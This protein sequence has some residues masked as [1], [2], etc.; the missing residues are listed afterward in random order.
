MLHASVAGSMAHRA[1]MIKI[2]LDEFSLRIKNAQQL[3]VKENIDLLFAFG[4]EAEPQYQ[5]YFSNYWPSFETAAVIIGKIGEPILLVGPE[6]LD[7]AKKLGTIAKVRK[8]SVFRESASPAYYDSSFSSMDQVIDECIGGLSLQRVSIAGNRLLPFDI[9]DELKNSLTK[10]GKVDI[11]CDTIVDTLRRKKT[12]NEL[13]CIQK[14]CNISTLALDHLINSMHVGLTE[15]QAKGIALSK[16]YEL[17]AEGEGY[18]FWIMSGE[19]SNH[20]I[21][22]ASQKKIS[23]GDMVQ[24]QIGARYEG[25]SSSI[26]RPIIIGQAQSWMVPAINAMRAGEAFL[27]E[28]LRSGES[29]KKLAL[30]FGKIMKENGYYGR[31]LYG[32]CHSLGM[33]ECEGPWIEEQSDFCLEE[34]MTFGIDIY[35]DFPEKK[36]GMRLED[37]A[38]VGKQRGVLMTKYSNEAV[39]L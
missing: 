1:N 8:L 5:K 25:Y 24:L 20:A 3:M 12:S 6:S 23:R 7:R 17:G 38:C 9:Y 39:I 28:N 36:Y 11:I 18:P 32:P 35:L 13:A 37:T 19:G 27:I 16:I 31:L 26:A 22:R 34:G 21:G 29:S 30:G 2:P 4:N 14:A 10:F 15:L 33:A